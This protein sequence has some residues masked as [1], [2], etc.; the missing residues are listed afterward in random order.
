MTIKA[1]PTS[2]PADGGVDGHGVVDG[3]GQGHLLVQRVVGAVRSLAQSLRASLLAQLSRDKPS[4]PVTLQLLA[5][6]RRLSA[7]ELLARKRQAALE[8]ATAGRLPDPSVFS[9]SAQEDA[10]VVRR[11]QVEFLGCRDSWHSAELAAIPQQNPQQY[12]IRV[13]ELQRA[14]WA[15]VAAQF[16]AVCNTIRPAA[17]VTPAASAPGGAD[18]HALSPAAASRALLAAW[19]QGR[20][21]WFTRVLASVLPR[22]DDGATLASL[23]QQATYAARRSGRLGADYAHLLPPLFL[24]RVRALATGKIALAARAFR[25]QILGWQWAYRP[26]FEPSSAS[27]TAAAAS[28]A[29]G[30]D[31]ARAASIQ[32]AVAS[33]LAPPPLLQRLPPLAE[34]ANAVITLYNHLRHCLPVGCAWLLSEQAQADSQSRAGQGGANAPLASAADTRPSTVVGDASGAQPDEGIDS[35]VR[36]RLQRSQDGVGSLLW[37]LDAASQA[38]LEAAKAEACPVA[39]LQV[40]RARLR[41]SAAPVHATGGAGSGSSGGSGDAAASASY[42]VPTLSADDQAALRRFHALCTAF[43]EVLFPF[44]AAVVLHLTTAGATPAASAEKGAAANQSAAAAVVSQDALI[45]S[46]TTGNAALDAAWTRVRAAAEEASRRL[47]AA[48]GTVA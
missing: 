13:V 20:I 40:A 37:L 15:D 8:Q 43:S 31:N 7:Q 34:I 47:K 3:R 41:A 10:A 27:A 22:I 28:Q 1:V 38:L 5:L 29:E 42:Y 11:V 39:A 26:G 9:L 2:R 35:T 17:A 4:L 12:L 46:Q 33:A 45:A 36:Q 16:V 6:L 32:D 14:A 19:I 18:P 25:S 24:T 21:G 44:L 23:L 30:K 48:A